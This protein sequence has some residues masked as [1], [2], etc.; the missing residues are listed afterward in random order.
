MTTLP[1]GTAHHYALDRHTWMI[2]YGYGFTPSAL[3]FMLLGIATTGDVIGAG[4]LVG[5][6]GKEVAQN[7]F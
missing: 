1:W 2:E 7:L 6:Y 5:A 4:L 3:P